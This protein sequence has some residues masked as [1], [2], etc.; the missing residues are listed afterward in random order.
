MSQAWLPLAT[1]ATALLVVPL[2]VA[3]PERAGRMRTALHLIAALRKGVL[4]A[5]MGWGT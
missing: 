2:I 1:L 5:L 4:V 3:L